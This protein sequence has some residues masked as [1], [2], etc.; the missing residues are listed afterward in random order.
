M[1][2]SIGFQMFI[3]KDHLKVL[4][5]KIASVELC[6]LYCIALVICLSV[7]ESAALQSIF[8]REP[9]MYVYCVCLGNFIY[10]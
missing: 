8:I 9:S 5:Y 7:Y 10:G 2:Y 4:L 1:N 3:R 6:V